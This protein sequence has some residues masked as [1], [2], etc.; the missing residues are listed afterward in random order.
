MRTVGAEG[1]DAGAPGPASA[2]RR[3]PV[4]FTSFLSKFLPKCL[5][6]Y[7]YYF[8]LFLG[9]KNRHGAGACSGGAAVALNIFLKK[10]QF[11]LLVIQHLTP[12]SLKWPCWHGLLLPFR[13]F[14][15]ESLELNSWK[16]N[17]SLGNWFVLQANFAL[18]QSMRTKAIW[19]Q[20]PRDSLFEY[21]PLRSPSK[22]QVPTFKRPINQRF[23]DAPF[24]ETRQ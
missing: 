14:W 16:I 13:L 12:H 2:G 8:Y 24:P 17:E 7:Y 18:E 1:R 22:R 9:R 15:T 19:V 23:K 11:R 6:F 20:H 3:R 5:I 10:N 4:Q 21:R